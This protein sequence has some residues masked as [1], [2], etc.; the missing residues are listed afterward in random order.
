MIFIRKEYQR[1]KY[2]KFHLQ[3]RDSDLYSTEQTDKNKPWSVSKWSSFE[4]CRVDYA[5]CLLSLLF[6]LIALLVSWCVTVRCLRG[7]WS[8]CRAI[9]IYRIGIP[10]RWLQ[11][12]S[13][14]LSIGCE[15]GFLL[16][17]VQYLLISHLCQSA[18]L[19]NLYFNNDC[20]YG[21]SANADDYGHY[22]S[23][24]RVL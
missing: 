22:V 14:S 23:F 21:I 1:A 12:T 17:N 11:M 6:L 2:D 19:I 8:G 24:S 13:F 4:S 16:S 15:F 20:N 3:G 10:P 9:C 18:K 5:V 7:T